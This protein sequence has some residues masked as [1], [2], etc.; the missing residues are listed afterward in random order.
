ME[1]KIEKREYFE[2]VE[3]FLRELQAFPEDKVVSVACVALI[4]DPDCGYL[5]VGHNLEPFY[6]MAMSGYLGVH[7]NKQYLQANGYIAP[8][9][10]A[11]EEEGEADE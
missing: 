10:D 9:N 7:A 3:A 2:A 8:D 11:D 1:N 5:Y 6:L 4:D